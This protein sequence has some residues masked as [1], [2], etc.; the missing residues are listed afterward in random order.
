MR[1]SVELCLTGS[2]LRVFY[3]VISILH[4]DVFSLN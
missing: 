4:A 3:T 1:I 2:A